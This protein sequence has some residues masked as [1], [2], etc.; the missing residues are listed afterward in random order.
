MKDN[1]GNGKQESLT[2]YDT[3]VTYGKSGHY[4]CHMPGHKRKKSDDILSDIFQ[5]DI[6]EIDDFDNLHQAQGL[7][8][9]AQERAAR[10]YGAEESFFLINGSTCGVLS[11]ILSVTDKQD[12]VLIARNCHKSVYH[13]AFIQELHLRYLY[14]EQ[15]AEYGIL[16]AV[17][18][19][20]VEA[21][22]ERYPECKA[23][24]ITSPTYEGVVS[25]IRRISEIVH[26]KGKVLIV[27]EAHGAHFGLAAGMP[28]NAVRQG[29]DLVIHSLHKTLPSMTQTALLHVKSSR[30]NR[31]KLRRYLTVFQS[32]SPSYVLMASMDACLSYLEK[33][34]LI[35]FAKLQK[36][37]QYFMKKMEDCRNIRIVS[38]GAIPSGKYSF[39]DWDICKLV[40]SVKGTS[41]NG[42]ALYDVLRNEFHLQMEM[43]A[44]TYVLAIMTIA[45]EI[46]DWQRLADALAQIDGKIEKADSRIEEKISEDRLEDHASEI[47]RRSPKEDGMPPT[48]MTIAQALSAF[49]EKTPESRSEVLLEQAQGRIL[50]DFINLYPPGIPI[51]VPGETATKGAIR[52]IRLSLDLGLHVQGVSERGTVWVL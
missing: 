1:N 34:A 44:D 39:T 18:P 51:L 37:L 50:A 11:A 24:V 52:R 6:T 20:D 13:A 25:D 4:P 21:A 3:L 47:E 5:L 9:Q 29:A 35:C 12:T 46:S 38:P 49:Y 31:M 2:L 41:M 43:A 45:D 15:I 30:I 42:Q 14:P 23:V 26:K 48:E 10:L 17:K 16:G 36:N 8:R 32:S 27:D 7:I 19:E 22:L 40:I 28:E 33:N